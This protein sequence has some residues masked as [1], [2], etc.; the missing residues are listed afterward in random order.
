[1]AASRDPSASMHINHS[2]MGRTRSTMARFQ[3]R[4]ERS[5]EAG[6]AIS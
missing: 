5:L 1:M 4:P 3:G 2:E 6:N